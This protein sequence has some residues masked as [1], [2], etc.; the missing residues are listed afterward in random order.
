PTRRT[1]ALWGLASVAAIATHY[2]AAFLVGAEA[3]WLLWSIRRPAL[4]PVAVV[5]A[6]GGALLPLAIHQKANG[7]AAFIGG[8][9]LVKRI[10][11][12]PKQFAT[13]YHGPLEVAATVVVLA[14]VALA[15]LRLVR[16]PGR[17]T[18]GLAAIALV[19][20]AATVVFAKA[21]DDYVITRNEL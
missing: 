12:I 16:N 9:S 2:Y 21:G 5:A 1:L 13:G 14:L 18:G 15:W 8:T 4:V 11:Q 20:V 7:G 19:A 17:R 10:A 3:L 6:V